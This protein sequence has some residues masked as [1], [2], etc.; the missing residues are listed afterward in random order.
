MRQQ[1][2]I[3]MLSIAH[4]MKKMR[5]KWT[6]LTLLLLFLYFIIGFLIVGICKF[7]MYSENEHLQVRLVDKDKSEETEL[8]IH[9][10][11]EQTDL[12]NFLQVISV[13]EDHAEKMLHNDDISAYVMFPEGFTKDLYHG[14]S[15]EIPVIGS[16]KHML[17]SELI[18][19]FV[20]S[21]M[22]LIET[23]QANILTIY[24]YAEELP[25]EEAERTDILFDEFKD[26][27]F[28]TIHKDDILRDDVIQN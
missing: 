4:Y 8:I 22:R 14:Q 19:Q 23:A 27:F 24:A 26:F 5:R 12:A 13:E 11:I 18:Y 6:S 2:R 28:Y 9:S 10:F 15:I 1:I 3:F 7:F 25:M 17:E 20:R 21:I 16:E